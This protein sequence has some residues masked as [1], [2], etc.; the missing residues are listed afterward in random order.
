MNHRLILSGGLAKIPGTYRVAAIV[1]EAVA[2]YVE[3]ANRI[4]FTR[5]RREISF[6]SVLSKVDD[7]VVVPTENNSTLGCRRRMEKKSR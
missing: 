1:R 3:D 4:G 6:F 7:T 5:S 2:N